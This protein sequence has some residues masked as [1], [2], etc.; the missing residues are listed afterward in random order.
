MLDIKFIR[1]NADLV[2]KTLQEKCLS[3]DIDELLAID[4]KIIQIKQLM[5]AELQKRNALSKE[6]PQATPERR[7]EIKA[8]SKQSGQ[9]AAAYAEELKPLEEQFKSMMGMTPTI[10]APDV[11]RGMSEEENVVVRQVGEKPVFDFE[12]KDHVALMDLNDWGEFKKISQICGSR[13][14]GI[15]GELLQLEMALWQYTVNKLMTKGFQVMSVPSL[16]FENAFYHTGHFPFDY[17]SV[18]SMPKDNLF[19]AGT[20]EVILNSIHAGDILKE[21]DLPIMYAGFSP[22]FRREAGAAGKDTRG[23]IR[24]HQ[25][26]K[27]EQYIICKADIAESDKMH[28]FILQNA[29][30]VM[31]D[32]EIP[33]QIIA[34]CTGDMGAGKYRMNDIEAWY[35]GQ[36]KYRET[37]SCSSLLDWQARRTNI[38]YREDETGKVK[39]AY[40][41]NNTG[42]ATPRV[43]VAFIENHQQA[44]GSVKIP[45]ALQP[46][47]GGKTKIGGK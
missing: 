39:Y 15:K 28:N 35:P 14:V 33:Y 22:C 32:M 2:K 41:L 43:L 40:T 44:D 3:L 18:Y 34:N 5:E 23:L 16:S 27:V 26:S 29:E 38:R 19:L 20:A 6:M 36:D 30:E 46:Y 17:E 12:M 25:F 31:Q 47:M 8:L 45:T 11:P 10:P 13:T 24:V 37:H 42:L 4:K 7:E 9:Q 21:A 1:E